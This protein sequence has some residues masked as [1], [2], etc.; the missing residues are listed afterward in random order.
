LVSFALD[1]STLSR[2]AAMERELR[3]LVMES[4]PIAISVFMGDPPRVVDWN[5]Q[6]RRMLG[7]DDDIQR[8][9]ELDATQ[10]LFDVRFVDGTPLTVDNAPVTLAIRSGEA[11]GPFYLRVRRLDGSE[12]ITRTHCAPFVDPDGRVAGAVVTSEEVDMAPVQAMSR[13]A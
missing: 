3:S 10:G 4:L 7:L 13:P 5:R 9:S 8:P 1:R 2:D 11:A 6:E 12:T